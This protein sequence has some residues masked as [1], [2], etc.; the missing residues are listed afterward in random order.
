M[1]EIADEYPGY[2]F[3]KNV[4]YGTKAHL[5]GLNSVLHLIIVKALNQSN[6]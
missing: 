6:L 2:E 1:K 3:E 5:D 4:G